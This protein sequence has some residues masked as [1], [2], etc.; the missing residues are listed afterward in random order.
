MNRIPVVLVDDHLV[1][2]R[3]IQSFLSAMPDMTV[4]G[5]ASSGEELLDKIETWLPDVVVMDL[6]MPGGIDGIETTRRLRDITP[7]TQVVVLTAHTDDERVI[8]ALRAG[9]IGYVRKESDPDLLVNAIRAAT[10]GQSI[11]DPSVA[12]AVLRDMTQK[13]TPGVELTE[14]EREVLIELAHGLTN[15][16]IAEKLFIGDETVK[17][18]VGNILSK[19]HLQHRNQAILYALKKRLIS[20]DDI[21]L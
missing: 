8:A 9:A 12:G 15:H 5:M 6:Y 17:T 21:E 1:V 7:H 16:Q 10:K 11:I 4:V 14:R 2:R 13:K 19:L 18:H 20:L 3:G